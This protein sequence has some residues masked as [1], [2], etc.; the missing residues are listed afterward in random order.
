M[1]VAAL[2]ALGLGEGNLLSFSQGSILSLLLLLGAAAGPVQPISAELAVEVP[3]LT[4]TIP[5][6]RSRIARCMNS[7]FSL[8][9]VEARQ[10]DG[11]S[12]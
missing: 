10:P 8:A 11:C 6:Q 3:P 4:E 12:R 9:L 2:L 7:V 5:N 1:A